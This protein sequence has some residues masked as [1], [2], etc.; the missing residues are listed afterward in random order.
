MVLALALAPAGC[1]GDDEGRGDSAEE[2]QRARSAARAAVTAVE[3]CFVDMADYS[4]CTGAETLNAADLEAGTDPG[5]VEISEAGATS[6]TATAY[7]SG[8]SWFAITRRDSGMERGCKAPPE[9]GC[10][11]GTW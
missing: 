10:E 9:A 7:L 11:G 6:Y 1:G 8:G 2:G 5:Q 4:R 3:A